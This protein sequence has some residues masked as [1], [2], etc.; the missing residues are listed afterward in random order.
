VPRSVSIDAS[1]I[2]SRC[3]LHLGQYILVFP[4]ARLNGSRVVEASYCGQLG[5]AA[6]G[7]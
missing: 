6:M 2:V 1:G 5:Y 3:V 7:L 4:K